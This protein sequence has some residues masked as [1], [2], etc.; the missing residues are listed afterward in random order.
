MTTA[1][2]TTVIT[3]MATAVLPS[4]RNNAGTD[5]VFR[6]NKKAPTLTGE[7]RPGLLFPVSKPAPQTLW[8]VALSAI[9]TLL[10]EPKS[11][12]VNYGNRKT[13]I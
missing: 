7:R 13:Q 2:I 1:I 6:G 11:A 10:P 8:P 3:A 12:Q 9:G 4:I 5:G